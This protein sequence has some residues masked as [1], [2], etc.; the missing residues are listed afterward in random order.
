MRRHHL[1]E[2]PFLPPSLLDAIVPQ[3]PQRE[4]HKCRP[5]SHEDAAQDGTTGDEED[6]AEDQNDRPLDRGPERIVLQ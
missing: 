5:E 3:E 2:S 4:C 6:D 1:S